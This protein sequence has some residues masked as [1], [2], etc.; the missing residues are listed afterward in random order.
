M[1]GL[2]LDLIR[3]TEIPLP[4]LAVQMGFV[5]Q[6]KEADRLREKQSQAM[7]HL[8]SLFASLQHRAFR[9]EL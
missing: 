8:D 4:P 7:D 6:M 3:D 2:N 5:E 9:V 1:P